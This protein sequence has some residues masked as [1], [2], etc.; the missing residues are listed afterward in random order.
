MPEYKNNKTGE[1]R[2]FS[3]IR[4]VPDP[5]TLEFTTINI[6]DSNMDMTDWVEFKDDTESTSYNTIA[7]TKSKTDGVGIR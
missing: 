3:R 1:V 5:N 6:A 7:V 4:R 2:Y